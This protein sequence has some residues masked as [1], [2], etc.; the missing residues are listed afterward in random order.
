MAELSDFAQPGGARIFAAR[1]HGVLL[2]L[3]SVGAG[4]PCIMHSVQN[5]V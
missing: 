5:T 2:Q 4:K 3:A 1:A